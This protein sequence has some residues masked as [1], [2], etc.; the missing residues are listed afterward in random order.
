MMIIIPITVKNIIN[1]RLLLVQRGLPIT[2]ILRPE[3]TKKR[4][5][6]FRTHHHHRVIHTRPGLSAHI[7][8]V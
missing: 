8:C 6:T 1:P 3:P 7:L 2:Y 4:V 5:K